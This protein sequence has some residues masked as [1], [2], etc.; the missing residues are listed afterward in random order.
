METVAPQWLRFEA[1]RKES[2]AEATRCLFVLANLRPGARVLDVGS[3]S[4]DTALLAAEQA[5]PAGWVLATDVSR[6]K[7]SGLLARRR[8]AAGLAPIG[9]AMMG[10]EEL[11]LRPQSF[12]AALSRNCLMYVSNVP[13]A[14]RA[15]RD[16]LRPGARFAA[17]VWGA[18]E[19][20]PFHAV[21]IAVVKQLGIAPEPQPEYVRAFSLDAGTLRRFFLEAG[22]ENVGLQAVS[23]ARSYASLSSAL[24]LLREFLPLVRLLE[25]VPQN[26]R[27]L[28]WDEIARGFAPFTGNAGLRF[29]GEQLVIAGTR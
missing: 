16:S 15:I 21:P 26:L 7:V 22:F 11:A 1:Q 13:R 27:Q 25:Y 20:N 19:R 4:G 6:E 29:P 10:A 14:L 23:A 17:S 3:G 2:L 5:G 18:L 28:A 24:T 8:I 9:V 12:D